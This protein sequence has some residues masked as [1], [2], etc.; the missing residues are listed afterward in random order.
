MENIREIVADEAGNGK[1]LDAYISETV[2]EITRSAAQK[3][4][5]EGNITVNDN[6]VAKNHRVVLGETIKIVLP[7]PK[8]LNT[9]P[10]DIDLDIVYED[11]SVIVVNKPKGM[12][13]HPAA[14]N[15][16]GTLV[17][18]LLYHCKGRLSGING[19]I[20][21]GIIHRIDKDTS[22]LLVVAKTDAAHLKLAEQVKAHSFTR[23]YE[24]IAVGNIKENEGFVEA[25]IGRDE[26]NR[27]KMAVTNKNSKY[28]YTTYKVVCRYEGYTRIE[29]ILKTGRTH[30]IRTHMAYIGHPLAGDEVYGGRRTL[31]GAEKKLKGQCLHAKKLGFIHPVSGEYMEFEAPMPEYFVEFENILKKKQ[32]LYKD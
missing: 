21:P 8:E 11:D 14:G 7:E 31:S 12:V 32:D 1:R 27:K 19:V 13:V 28:A 10:Q 26:K 5:A 20:R 24:A 22:G 23:V 17:N 4:I 9:E 16:D 2:G 25:P 29:L 15:Y 18:A 3:L 30:Q 6:T